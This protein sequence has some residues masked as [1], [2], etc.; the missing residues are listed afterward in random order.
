MFIILDLQQL[1]QKTASK[2][3]GNDYIYSLLSVKFEFMY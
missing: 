2:T 3:T 1:V